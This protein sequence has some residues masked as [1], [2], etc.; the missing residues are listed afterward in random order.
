M[1]ISLPDPRDIV[2][3]AELVNTSGGNWGY[4]TIVIQENDR[5]V[6]KWQS[7]FD[8]MSKQRL[9]PI[10]R[11]ATTIDGNAWRRPE[12]SDAESWVNFLSLLEWPVKYKYVVLFNEPNH[13]KEWGGNVDEAH[14]AEVSYEFA[15][16]LKAKDADFFV[17]WA[18]FDA[19]APSQMP[20][21]QDEEV[22]IQRMFSR[23]PPPQW[24]NI[25]D[26]LASHSYPR[27]F[28][29]SPAEVGR[30]TIRTYEWELSVLQGHGF[31]K[32][33]PVFITE[34]GWLNSVSNRADYYKAAFSGIWG[35]DS[36]V[37]AVTPFIL[38]YQAAPF[39]VFSWRKTGSD[40]FYE[41]YAVVQSLPKVA[42][43]PEIEGEYP[44]GF[45]D[46]SENHMFY[47]PVTNLAEDTIISGF[48]DGYFRPSVAVTRGA[49]AK[50]IK[51][52]Y[53][54]G[55]NTSCGNFPD[56]PSTHVF[57]KEITT[58]KCNGVISGY[59]DGTF[60]SEVNVDRGAAM[61]FVIEGL[62]KKNN[63]SNYLKYTGSA[64]PFSDVPTSYIF[65]EYIMA[66]YTNG[67][68]S[69]Y[70]DGTFKPTVTTDRG[71]M[72]KMVDNARN[73]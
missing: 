22:F 52:A 61:K 70:P 9:I 71:A 3:T 53:G 2:D 55:D 63:N 51:N 17:M 58:L 45:P 72:S 33:L 13:A 57:Y 42:G 47:T 8:E 48:P 50:F 1:H 5:D 21:L 20:T 23:I 36:R 49:M 19:A 67:I 34:T 15:T 29:G 69:G 37:V 38:T 60:K 64:Q 4:I 44:Y 59:P 41:H 28:T 11:I 7:M 62:R 31:T 35:T 65:Y 27:N 24:T 40:E 14:Y 6:T 39:D 25:I 66:A 32:Q 56:V 43:E 46:V 30:R 18:G 16:K 73:K 12:K 26:G 10:I 68:V 54:F